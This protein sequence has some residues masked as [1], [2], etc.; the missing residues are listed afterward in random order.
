[1]VGL[2]PPTV[3]APHRAAALPP[4][5]GSRVCRVWPPL[6]SACPAGVGYSLAASHP[7]PPRVGS[8]AEAQTPMKF[9]I[10]YFNKIPG[11]LS[12]PAARLPSPWRPVS[13]C[14][15]QSQRPQLLTPADP[16]APRLPS[17]WSRLQT[18]FSLLL[19]PSHPFESQLIGGLSRK[20]SVT[21]LPVSQ[22]ELTFPPVCP[23]SA[24][25]Q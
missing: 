5:L 10:W 18:P 25:S 17:H 9:F 15:S 4:D 22:V 3:A 11:T 13:C 12:F 16:C 14:A 24:C 19:T 1:M 8:W 21:T 2:A 7:W 6:S 23:H 20:L